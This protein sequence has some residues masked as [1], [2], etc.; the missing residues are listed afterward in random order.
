[1]RF[2]NAAQG[3]ADPTAETLQAAKDAWLAARPDYGISEAFRFYDG[4]IDNEE[5]RPEQDGVPDDSPGRTAILTTMNSLGDQTD[6]IVAAA[7]A[8]GL[9]IEVT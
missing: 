9:T 3:V 7:T 6:T 4:P 1:V 8:L 2:S 5:D